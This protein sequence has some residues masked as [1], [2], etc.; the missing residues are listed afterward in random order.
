MDTDDLIEMAWDVIVRAVHVSDALK[1][2]LG[3]T[4]SHFESEDE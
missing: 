2:E 3:A 1:T 4:P